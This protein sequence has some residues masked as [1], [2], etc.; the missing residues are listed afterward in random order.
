MNAHPKVSVKP[1]DR[2]SQYKND[3]LKNI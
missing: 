1:P 3:I 2:Q